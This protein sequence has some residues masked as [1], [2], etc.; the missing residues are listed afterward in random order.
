M[1]NLLAIAIVIAMLSSCSQ[2]SLT[3]VSANRVQETNHEV[4]KTDYAKIDLKH[5]DKV[6][7]N[8]QSKYHS[9]ANETDKKL[10]HQKN[11]DLNKKKGWD[12]E[13][14]FY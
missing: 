3:Q 11:E 9:Y 6:E 4:N 12:S 14:S 8:R 10:N 5:K 2:R 7:N 13:F 1:K